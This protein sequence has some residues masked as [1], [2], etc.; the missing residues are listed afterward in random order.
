MAPQFR[1]LVFEGGGVKGIA[2]VGAMEILQQRGQLDHILRVGGTSAGAI[3][4][5]IYA[6]GY[7]IRKQHQI[8]DS[9]DFD[10]SDDKK[11]GPDRAGYPRG[12]KLLPLV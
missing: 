1:N 11:T 7:T 4:A 5:L 12:G 2:Y 8:L 6:P 10:L 3:N 9:T